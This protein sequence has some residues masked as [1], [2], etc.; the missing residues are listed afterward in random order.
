MRKKRRAEPTAEQQS[1]A[2]PVVQPEQP[3]RESPLAGPCLLCVELLI[4]L[5]RKQNTYVT[6]TRGRVRYC[7]C[8]NCGHTW[9][10]IS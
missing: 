8:R 5:D 2:L 3:G 6:D 1:D 7:K 10:R 9:K 4:I